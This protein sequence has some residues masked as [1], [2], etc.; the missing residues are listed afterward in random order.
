MSK[1]DRSVLEQH[2]VHSHEEDNDKEMVF[3]PASY[4]F[5]PSRGRSSFDLKPDGSLTESGP[6]PTDRSEQ[7][8]GRWHLDANN[9]L[10]LSSG[11]RRD[12]ISRVLK[13]HSADRNRLVVKK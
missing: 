1:I 5:P 13:V 4:S 10:T 6:G 9:N 12:E 2:W 11:S 8:A 3:R 7:K